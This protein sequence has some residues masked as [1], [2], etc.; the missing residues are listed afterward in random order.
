LIL[1]IAVGG[2]E[3]GT[4]TQ[5]YPPYGIDDSSGPWEMAIKSINYYRY[6]GD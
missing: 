6:T 3:G 4:E 5:Q 2:T 1:N